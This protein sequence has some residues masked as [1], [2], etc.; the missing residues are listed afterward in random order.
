MTKQEDALDRIEA[1]LAAREAAEAEYH[2][3]LLAA[4]KVG[5]T[6]YAIGKRTGMT[7]QGVRYM[8]KKL[9]G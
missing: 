4:D 8:L 3:A 5:V 9:K 2:A 7:A 1:A 6:S